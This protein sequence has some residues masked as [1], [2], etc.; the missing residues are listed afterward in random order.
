MI[1]SSLHLLVVSLFSVGC[2]PE[3][4]FEK[5]RTEPHLHILRPSDGQLFVEHEL[6]EFY[7]TAQDA[8]QSEPPLTVW[9]N[10]DL[11]GTLFEGETDTDGES[12]FQTVNLSVGLH[13]ITFI[14]EESLN[15]LCPLRE[16][17]HIPFE[18]MPC[19]AAMFGN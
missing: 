5:Y 15:A 8:D 6:V 2:N 12:H 7:G 11:D 13:A 3:T 16:L 9:W 17:Y 1:R 19:D 4:E 10:S 18:E 14:A